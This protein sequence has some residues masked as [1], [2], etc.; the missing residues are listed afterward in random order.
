MLGVSQRTLQQQGW[1]DRREGR[2]DQ[3]TTLPFAAYF[4]A[5]CESPE[6]PIETDRCQ[7]RER[8][9]SNPRPLP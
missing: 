1:Q 6:K 5:I 9:D 3:A 4:Q 7:E 2:G 8:R